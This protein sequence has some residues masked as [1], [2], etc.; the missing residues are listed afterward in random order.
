MS[1]VM[2]QPEIVEEEEHLVYVLQAL[3]KLEQALREL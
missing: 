1:D 3:K 2:V